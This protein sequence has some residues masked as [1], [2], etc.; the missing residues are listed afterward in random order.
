VKERSSSDHK[1]SNNTSDEVRRGLSPELDL[2]SNYPLSDTERSGTGEIADVPDLE[3]MPNMDIGFQ[4]DSHRSYTPATMELN[5]PT[6]TDLDSLMYPSAFDYSFIDQD[7]NFSLALTHP[8]D[9]DGLVADSLL[10]DPSMSSSLG[11]NAGQLC[12]LPSLFDLKQSDGCVLNTSESGTYTPTIR[13]SRSKTT[14]VMED[15]EPGTL[16]KVIRILSEANTKIS[17][18]SGEEDFS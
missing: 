16:C 10:W 11:D 18:H 1:Y 9:L 4:T 5:T 2:E 14:L 3:G 15:V 6:S 17:M 8:S 13:R 7:P 12:R